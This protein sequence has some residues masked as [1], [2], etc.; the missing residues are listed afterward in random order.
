MNSYIFIEATEEHWAFSL[1]DFKYFW[2]VAKGVTTHNCEISN[3]HLLVCWYQAP[4]Y[5]VVVKLTV[6]GSLV[7]LRDWTYPGTSLCPTLPQVS[8]TFPS[9]K[10]PVRW[11]EEITRLPMLH[12]IVFTNWFVLTGQGQSFFFTWIFRL[13]S[14]CHDISEARVSVTSG[15]LFVLSSLTIR[16]FMSS[17]LSPQADRFMSTF[18]WRCIALLRLFKGRTF[19]SKAWEMK[20]C[21]EKS[22][23]FFS[24]HH[25]LVLIYDWIMSMLIIPYLFNSICSFHIFH[26][27]L[28]TS[29]YCSVLINNTKRTERPVLAVLSVCA[30]VWMMGLPQVGTYPDIDTNIRQ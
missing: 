18:V 27:L 13:P 22:A 16:L 20:Q 19:Y 6:W 30:Y 10:Q 3:I 24:H 26:W 21:L 12:L 25:C 4:T 1:N 17:D 7:K 11:S 5:V 15:Y 28:S 14:I 8:N 29:S 9:V 2:S 23:L